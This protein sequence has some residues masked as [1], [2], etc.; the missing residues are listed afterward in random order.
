MS[1]SLNNP[2]TYAIAINLLAQLPTLVVYLIGMVLAIRRWQRHPRI[3]GLMLAAMLMLLTSTIFY[4]FFYLWLPYS[5]Y[6]QTRSP[7]GWTSLY[8]VMTT[9]RSVVVALGMGL[10]LFAVFAMRDRDRDGFPVQFAK[11]ADAQT[12]AAPPSDQ[13]PSPPADWHS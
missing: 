12:P 9:V 5:P 7:A 2:V 11:L 4:T 8:F 1:L 6:W 3:S 10:W 13:A